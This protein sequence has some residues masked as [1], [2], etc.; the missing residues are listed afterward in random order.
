MAKPK[1]DSLLA[2]SALGYS[3]IWVDT[4]QTGFP[5]HEGTQHNGPVRMAG[6]TVIDKACCLHA[7]I[8][9]GDGGSGSKIL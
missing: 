5:L 1:S 2:T 8:A 7:L 4:I 3:L 9:R 6:K